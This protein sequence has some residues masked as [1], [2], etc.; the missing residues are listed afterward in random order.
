RDAEKGALWLAY[1]WLD[2]SANGPGGFEF[3]VR[4]HL[5]KS[6]DGGRSFAFAKAAN[7]V[8]REAR[9]SWLAEVPALVRASPRD[10]RLV[11]LRYLPPRRAA[12]HERTGRRLLGGP[13]RGAR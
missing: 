8:E 1:S 9:G 11:W 6:D 3:D 13:G 7:E 2:A 10:W 12:P 5:A 4:T